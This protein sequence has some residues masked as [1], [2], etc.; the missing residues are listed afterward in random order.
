MNAWPDLRGTE[1]GVA[2]RRLTK[3]GQLILTN[4]LDPASIGRVV[5][6]AQDLAKIAPIT[7]HD[8]RRTFATRLL[9]KNVDIVAVKISWGTPTF[10]PQRNTT[11][12]VKKRCNICAARRALTLHCPKPSL[13][14]G[15]TETIQPALVK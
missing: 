3:G 6:H 8:L 7:T 5:K 9:A 15:I 12:A 11:D 10:R 4:P 14:T 1:P 13:R 2:L